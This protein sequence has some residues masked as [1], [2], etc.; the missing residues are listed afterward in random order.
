MIKSK[1]VFHILDL[2]LDGADEG[3]LA[4]P[5][6]NYLSDSNYEYTGAGLFV[7]FT[8]NAG[9]EK[10]RI[11]KENLVLNGVKLKSPELKIEADAILF[12]KEGLIDY[13]EIWSVD[14]NYPESDLTSYELSQVWDNSP[15]RVIKVN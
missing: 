5:Q 15:K 6:I 8:K 9:I 14:G 13:L 10:F 4:R 3:K 7:F 2:I 11:Q 12:F 1:F